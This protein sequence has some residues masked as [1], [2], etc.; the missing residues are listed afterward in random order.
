MPS[1]LELTILSIIVCVAVTVWIGLIIRR[2]KA[3]LGLPFAFALL[4]LLEHLPGAWAA[5]A[6]GERY[7][8]LA[9][10]QTGITLTATSLCAFAGGAWLARAKMVRPIISTSEPQQILMPKMVTPR[11]IIFCLFGGWLFTFAGRALIDIPSINAVVDKS[12][13]IWLLAVMLG[14]AASLQRRSIY[15][16]VLWI[17]ALLVYPA[18]ILIIGGFASWG[19]ASIVLVVS[20][21]CVVLKHYWV[22]LV[23]VVIGSVM[24]VSLFVNYFEIRDELRVAAWGGAP[25]AERAAI[26]SKMFTDFEFLSTDNPVHLDALDQRLNQNY[27]IGLAA[28][29]LERGQVDFLLGRSIKEGLISLVPRVIWPEKPVLGGSGDI[30]PEMTGL[31]LDRTNTAWGVGSVMEF[32]VNFGVTGILFGFLILGYALA[33]LDFIAAR[34]L[35]AGHYGRS[36]IPFLM[37][38]AL[39]RPLGSMVELVSGAAAA[40]VGGIAW[41][42]LWNEWSTRKRHLDLRRRPPLRSLSSRSNGPKIFETSRVPPPN[43]TLN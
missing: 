8:R 17:S 18:V 19:S 42:W 15:G 10:V 3:S 32:Y 35:A 29:R 11:F 22:V 21:L 25:I 36:L 40:Y 26:A 13:T 7:S 34:R 30:V 6:A 16:L 41:C 20:I 9:F 2:D 37:C 33:K 12:G 4:L 31:A 43:I 39:V 5:L 24:A 28:Y 38:V 1:L 23:G 14:L 27:F